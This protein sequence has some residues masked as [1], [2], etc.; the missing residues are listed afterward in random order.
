MREAIS[1]SYIFAIVITIIGVCSI[2][3]ISSLSYSKTYKTK[4]RIIEIIEK[5]QAYNNDEVKDE[6]DSLLKETG[7]KIK[8]DN[9]VCPEGRGPVVEGLQS[10]NTAINT[11]DNYK[12]CIYKYDTV[13]GPYYSVVVYMAFEFPLISDFIKLEFPIYGDTKVFQNF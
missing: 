6:I 13:K 8:K 4:N 7:Y 9:S 5:Y 11:L 10:G 1:D 2:I 3:I 12:Y